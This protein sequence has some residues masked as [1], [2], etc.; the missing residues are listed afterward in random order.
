[1]EPYDRSDLRRAAEAGV[2]APSMFNSQP[3]AFR[4]RDGV[5]EVLSDPG[6]RLVVADNRG[7]AMRLACGAATFN[8]R[9]ALASAGRP[10]DVQV[11]PDEGQ[12][13]VIARL[14]PAEFRPISCTE[15]D[16]YR[17]VERRYSN[18]DPFW[19]DPVPAE[20]RFR[21]I[22]AARAEGCRLDLLVGETA[23]LGFAQIAHSADHV[24]R[25]DKSYQAE[26]M[27][28]TSTESA[29][30]VPADVPVGR[31][32]AVVPQRSFAGQ[33]AG[34][35]YEPEPLIAVLG[36]S[37]DRRADQVMAGQALQRVLLT[38]TDAGLSSSMISQP[39]EVQAARD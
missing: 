18:R 16:L 30:T 26:M 20:T 24:L 25:R 6:R 37:D 38:A 15:R 32:R 9:L 27:T 31:E 3:W 1:M 2:H 4:L 13:E 35:A 34:Q 39:I 10:A 22:E 19:P 29:D 14:S 11:L 7:W 23:L 36:T 12:T 17:A 5:I 21:L 8:A 33:P 28:W